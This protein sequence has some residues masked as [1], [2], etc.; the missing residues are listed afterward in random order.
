M[1]EKINELKTKF[2]QSE[3]M[4]TFLQKIADDIIKRLEFG[5]GNEQY[6]YHWL[7]IGASLDFWCKEYDIYLN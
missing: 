2:L 6:F 3:R 4:V 7:S 5:I 1:K